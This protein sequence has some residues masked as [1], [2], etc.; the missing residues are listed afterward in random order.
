MEPEGS[1]PLSQ[2]PVTFPVWIRGSCLRFV[3]WLSF[4]GEEFLAT[5]PTPKLDDNPMSAVHGC[6]FN[7]FAT[8]LHV[9][10]PFFHPL[11]EEAPSRGDRNPLIKVLFFERQEVAQQSGASHLV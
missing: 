3:T 8:T 11:P 9:W 7:K 1:S 4:Y 10:R 6:L 2:K 5:R